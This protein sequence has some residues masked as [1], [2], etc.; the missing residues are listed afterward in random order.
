MR[1][2]RSVCVCLHGLLV[3]Q[4]YFLVFY[5]VLNSSKFS[6][7]LKFYQY[8]WSKFSKNTDKSVCLEALRA[9]PPKSVGGGVG[10]VSY[11]WSLGGAELEIALPCGLAAV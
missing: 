6:V 2:S 4:V 9:S 1:E 8:L 11:V 3:I 7:F 10:V 5:R